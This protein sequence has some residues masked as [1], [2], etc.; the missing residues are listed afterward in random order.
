MIPVVGSAVDWT[1]LGKSAAAA[2]V[3]SIALIFAFSLAVFGTT[4]WAELRRGGRRTAES[5]VFAVVGLFGAAVVVAAVVGG[6]IV[7]SSK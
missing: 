4:R 5:G 3:S 7:M 2:L 6:I 1:A